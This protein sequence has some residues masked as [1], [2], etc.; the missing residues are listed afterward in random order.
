MKTSTPALRERRQDPR[1]AA[2][3]RVRF[4]AP[5]GVWVERGSAAIED[6]SACGLRLRSEKSLH[7]G[8]ALVLH[9]PGEALELHA[10]VLWVRENRARWFG[11]HREWTAGCRLL[12]DSISSVRFEQPPEVRSR[13]GSVLLKGFVGAIAAVGVVAVLVYAYWFFAMLMGAR[14]LR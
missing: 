10:R 14:V 5:D 2:S 9:V 8:E 7:P 13:W 3:A 12:G 6:A 4:E 11:R 1:M